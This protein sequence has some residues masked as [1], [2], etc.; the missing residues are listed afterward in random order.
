MSKVP[1][2]KSN[3]YLREASDLKAV[4]R[5]SVATSTAIEGVHGVLPKEYKP[6][7]KKNGASIARER[8]ASYRSRR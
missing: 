7:R 8:E 3:P 2:S 1:L 5:D 4:L 6:S